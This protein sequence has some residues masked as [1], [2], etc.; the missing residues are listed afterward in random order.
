M[1][2]ADR[3]AKRIKE[4]HL[5]YPERS[6]REWADD[7]KTPSGRVHVGSLR[8]V[9]VH[10][11]IYKALK[12]IGVDTKFSYVFNDMD[13]MDGMPSYLDKNKWGK[14]MGEPLYKI[15]SPESG[16]KS[17]A[18]YFA[19][20]FISVFNSINCKPQI[21]WSS[22]LH[23]AGKMNDVIKL[24]LD[25]ADVIRDIYK[26]VVKKERGQ[27][28]YPYNPICE[29][30]GKVGTTKVFKWD[31]KYVY[32]RCERSMVEWAE[33]CDYEGYVEPINEN[34]KLV[35]KLDWPAHWKVIG[36][37]IESSGKD[38]MSS[39]G[40]Y[41]M[42]VQFCKEVF[43]TTA[44]DAL[45]GYEWFTIGG[46][47]M[48]SS[49]GI[50]SS[51]KEV[52]QIL[53][54]ELLRFL[55]VRTP[56]KTHLDFDPIGDTI[57]NLFDD[58]D[59]CLNDYFLKL[60]NN[61]PKDKA[62]EVAADFARIIELSEVNPLPKTRIYV[63]R[64][65]TIVNL[66]KTNKD[67][68]EKFF[69]SQKKSSLSVIEK[70]VLEERIKYAKI[71]LKKY[72]QAK[73]DF[74][75]IK[76]FVPNEIQRSFLLQSFNR[77]K[78]LKNKDDKNEIQKVVF[79]LIKEVGIKPKE[80]FEVIYQSLIGKPFGP[81]IGE[82]II[83]LGFDKALS[84]LSSDKTDSKLITPSEKLFPDFT[85]KKIFSI[86]PEVAK[87]YPSI[88]IG[89]AIIKDIKIKKTDPELTKEIDAFLAQQSHL[90][91]EVISSYPE[92]VTYRKLYK[93]MGID[94]HS[95]RPSPEALLR[96]ISQ[97]KNL[98][99]INTCVDAYNL[100]VMKNRVSVGAFN[101]DKFHFPTI[102]R[103]PKD[104]EEILLLGDR[105]PTKFKPKELAYFD[106]E[107]GYNIDFNY[108]DAQR[109]AVTEDTKN[110]LL[111]IDGIFDIGRE[112]VEKSLQESI[113]IILKYC[114]GHVVSA[115]IISA[116]QK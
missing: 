75:L 33:G 82:L 42:G 48:S 35:W 23:K 114:G 105:E 52:S 90:S 56:I 32:Y 27:D 102:M 97:K 43:N 78:S 77:L 76:T 70:Q 24:V 13:P 113:D 65:R 63:P 92:V 91:N 28:W 99:Q 22:E 9:I 59:R 47:K 18:D 16:F 71:Y 108:R 8:G 55:L 67:N 61:L 21:I 66:L 20:E 26:K 25:K 74:N 111:N 101:Y 79:D 36:I 46:R 88:N 109:T 64:F 96:R 37:T 106:E 116:A 44:P 73:V 93:E 45:G 34:G 49:K 84:L 41:D 100:I 58:Y 7:M 5:V 83:N 68:L 87:K 38:H 50:G 3:E 94:W 17:Y 30:C 107:G 98:Y 110:I 11:L 69:E 6:R 103:F 95:R 80:A 40:S 4:K 57:P 115:G 86:D 81:K 54:S 85:D 89:I 10:D 19:Q 31:G 14:H 51:A 15:P 2:W 112:K 1:I 72:S 62:G 12:D 53:P 29:K 39:G 104:G 60:E